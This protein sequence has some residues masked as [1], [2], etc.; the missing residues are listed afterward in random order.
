MNKFIKTKVTSEFTQIPNII[1]T[2]GRLTAGALRLILA[3]YSLPQNWIVT[4]SGLAGRFG[5]ARS[6]VAT[7]MKLLRELG[8]VDVVEERD[9]DGR[10]SYR[11][12][13][14][15]LERKAEKLEKA[16]AWKIIEPSQPVENFSHADITD[17]EKPDT[18]FTDTEKPDTVPPHTTNNVLTNTVKT[19]TVRTNIDRCPDGFGQNLTETD[20][21]EYNTESFCWE[22]TENEVEVVSGQFAIRNAQCAIGNERARSELGAERLPRGTSRTR[23]CTPST[24]PAKTDYYSIKS[25]IKS[26]LDYDVAKE[27]FDFAEDVVNLIAEELSSEDEYIKIGGRKYPADT[28]RDRLGQI[29]CSHLEYIDLAL[30]EKR[31]R[32]KNPKAYLLSMLFNA[33]ATINTYFENRVRSDAQCAMRNRSW[34]FT[35]H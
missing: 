15:D 2:D 28:V 20:G 25:R 34:L 29:K 24:V 22:G 30:S 35:D 21:D 11:Y 12:I 27:R 33:P 1:I 9:E 3:L 18:V 19:N 31:G 8:Y 16:A 7:S 6:T 4:L 23:Y 26:N 32:I 13:L 5:M 10:F 14:C 17:T